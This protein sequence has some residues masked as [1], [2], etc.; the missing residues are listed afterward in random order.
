MP[1]AKVLEGINDM[2]RISDA[3]MSGTAYGTVVL[4]WRRGQRAALAL[5]QRRHVGWTCRTGDCT[6]M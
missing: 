2:V 1:A 6:W 4:Q 3:R 5:V